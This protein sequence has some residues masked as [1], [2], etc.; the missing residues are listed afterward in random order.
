MCILNSN[1]IFLLSEDSVTQ[2]RC[3]VNTNI[4]VKNV[5]AS[6]RHIRGKYMC[7]SRMDLSSPRRRAITIKLVCLIVAP[8]TQ[9]AC[10]E[11]ADDLG[12]ASETL[13]VHG[14]AAAIH[15]AVLPRRLPPGAP[16]LQHLWGRHQSGEAL[17]PGCRRGALWEVCC[18]DH[19]AGRKC[20]Y[21]DLCSKQPESTNASV[22]KNLNK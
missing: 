17:R 15:Q 8:A 4:T 13:Q 18:R 7:W 9:D 11:A 2:R 16:P 12:S 6:R 1:H 3:A 22:Q 21:F 19:T 20:L 14:A 5:E 10:E